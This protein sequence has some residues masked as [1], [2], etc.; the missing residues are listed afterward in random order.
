[1]RAVYHERLGALRDAART[2]AAG[3]VNLRPVQA[4]LHCVAD[5]VEADAPRVAREAA[6]RG[7]EVMP[8]AAYC[9]DPGAAPPA[10]VLGFAAVRPEDLWDGM[11]RLM[12][13]IEA[14]RR[15]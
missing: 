9:A 15:S 5:L 11:R 6:A 13:A 7:V 10:L 2:L 4:G 3:A 12:S 8:L 14:A 1:M